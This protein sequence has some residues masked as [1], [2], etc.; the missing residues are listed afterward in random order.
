[1]WFVC[2]LWFAYHLRNDRY[3]T[4]AGHI[5]GAINDHSVKLW[6]RRA[7]HETVVSRAD[8]A[9]VIILHVFYLIL[10]LCPTPSINVS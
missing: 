5:I 2:A 10:L 1:V 7:D 4:V 3:E 9:L 6:W 8:T